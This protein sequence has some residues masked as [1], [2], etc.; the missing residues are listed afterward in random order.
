VLAGETDCPDASK[1]SASAERVA[2]LHQKQKRPHGQPAWLLL[3]KAS[4]P[5]VGLIVSWTQNGTRSSA[6]GRVISRPSAGVGWERAEPASTNRR[7]ACI[8]G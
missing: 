1:Q 3:V 6:S 5:A 8:C 4:A 7:L 2:R